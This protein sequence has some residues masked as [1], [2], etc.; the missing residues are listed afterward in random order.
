MNPYDAQSSLDDIRRLQDKTRDEYVRQGFALPYVVASAM[1]LL[2]WL[3]SIDLERPWNIVANVV[4]LVLFVG[5][6]IVH[7]HR[8]TVRRKPGV[9][10]TV[11]FTGWMF[12]LMM[13]FGLFRIV[14]W[15]LLDLPAQGFASQATFAAAAVAVTYVATTPLMRRAIRAI[16]QQDTGRA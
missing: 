12:G 1:G 2:I 13:A 15:T 8:A 14:G 3:A 11:L 16:I 10:D 7:P 5:A 4:G 9:P 6:G